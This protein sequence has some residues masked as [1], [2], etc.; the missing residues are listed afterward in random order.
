MQDHKH[1]HRRTRLSVAA[2]VAFGLGLT[3]VGVPAAFA[4]E[5][6]QTIAAVQ[7]TAETQGAGGASPLAGTTVTVEGIVTADH[8]GASGYRGIF[9]QALGSGGA[10]DATPGAS[11]GVFVYLNN[12]NPAV[13]IGDQ[14]TA[15]GVVTEYFGQTQL[16]AGAT[17][18]VVELVTPAAEVPAEQQV[19]A[20]AL[21]DTVVGADREAFEGM[22]VA[23]AGAY[24]VSSSHQL[25]NFGT[26]WLNA[27]ANAVKST[28]TTDAGADANAIAAA[29]RA[30]RILLDDGYNIQITNGSHPGTQPYFSTD[31]IVRGG[32]T[33]VWPA[34]PYVLG[35][36]FDDWRLQPTIPINDASPAEYK[37]TFDATNPRPGSAPAV[38]GDY[39]VGSF[40]VFN[41]FTTLT[42]E[43]SDARG[44]DN[45]ADFAIQQAKIVAAINALGADVVALQEI[46]NSIKLGEPAD[47]ALA[48]LVAAL[49]AAAGSAVWDYVRTPAALHN[50]AI[51]DFITNAII[52]KTDAVHTVGESFTQVDETV[53][54]IAR[55]P[56]AQT[57]EAVSTGKVFTV[58][59]NH[60]KSKSG[61]GA[62]P[63]DGQGHFN[64]ERVEQAGSLAALVDTIAADPEKSEDV[65]LVGDFNAYAQEDPIQVFTDAGYV[66][67]VPTHTDGQYT[68]TFDGELG[69]LDHVIAT[70]S[71][72]AYVTGA[73]VWSINS[74]EW[75]DRGYEFDSANASTVF[76]SSDH[77]PIKVGVSAELA[78]IEIE[79]LTVNDFHG[80]LEADRGI[81]GAAQIGGM[82]DFWEA[83]N[84]NTTFVGAGDFIGASTFTSFIQNDQPTID[85]LNA[86]GLDGSAL[87]NHEF[88]QGRADV[89]DRILN[90]ADWPY[91][92]ANLYDVPTG[93]P[94]YDE[95]FL[96]E[97][98]GVDVGFIGAVTEDLRELVSPAGIQSLEIRSIVDEVNRVADYLTDGDD[99]NGEADVLVLLVHEGAATSAIESS[100]DDSAFGQIVSDVSPEISAIVSGHT[101]L[102]YDHEVAVDGMDRP[103]LVISAGQYG[104]NY[105]HLDLSID[106]QTHEI[107]S[108]AGEVL[109]IGGFVPDAEVQAIVDEATA[110]ADVLGAVSVGEIT[111][112]FYRAVQSPFPGNETTPPNPFP[113]NRGGESTLGNF[114]ADVQLWAAAELGAHIA[115]MNPGGLRADLEVESSGEGDPDGNVTYRE[116][117]NVQPFANTLTT[118][119][120]TGAQLKQVLEEQWQPAG[121][122]RPFLKLGL[123]SGF[124]YV[125]DP[126]AAAG[127]HVTAMY[128]NGEAIDAAAEYK[129]VANS[130]LAAG[131]DNFFTLAEG[132]NVA[133]SGRV[134]LQA[135][136]DYF[137]E[138]PVATPSFEQNSVGVNP[139][140]PAEA[141]YSP[142]DEVTLDLS[143]LLFSRGGPTTGTVEVSVGET[144]LG[145]GQIDGTIVDT[146]DEQGRASVTVTI[147][148][149]TPSGVLLL[150]V[151]VPETGTTIDVPLEVTSDQEAIEVVD[152]PRIK[153]KAEVGK[154]L[155][156]DPGEW[157]VEDVEFSYQWL[158]DGQPIEGATDRK[159]AVTVDDI[160][161]ELS[162]M[163]TASKE[164]FANGT[165][166]TAAVAVDK[167]DSR[168]SASTNRFLIWGDQSLTVDVRVNVPKARDVEATGEVSIL[169]RGE[170]I[171]TATLDDRGRA[172][173]DLDDLESGFHWIT[174]EYAGTDLIDGSTSWP[175]L[176]V[177]F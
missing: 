100:T 162:A 71:A 16:G 122:Q 144:V 146:T 45:A 145:T 60:F 125:Y 93:E 160:G 62:E 14:V 3:T 96:Q 68:Y 89:D 130:F 143:S 135:M 23:P 8:R 124:E 5:P 24:K 165:A 25:H 7:G 12:A 114:V 108:F 175:H 78:P 107:L 91:V 85:V 87:G 1:T 59:A 127:S 150:T 149:G 17:P 31:T 141:G 92:A 134:D 132:T 155:R 140:P 81:P 106:P 21:A 34:N 128:L 38:G 118:M 116:A 28:E 176:V 11:D 153:G 159:Y 120:L 173:V 119:T 22:L 13:V 77:D 142:G 90:A 74:P 161:A 101:H 4:A 43:N 170:V 83:Q 126:D 86:I 70:P 79:I 29:N 136:V 109:P 131:G 40:N 111:D 174:V 52:F 26:L 75:S 99:T 148:E 69:S 137:E 104:A 163:V 2:V 48:D 37:P 105:G 121:A 123:S 166:E 19:S 67:L 168:V 49:N 9:V 156:V 58:V 18:A 169:V 103:R 61:S 139:T 15:T 157:S 57:F 10:A 97:F 84:S 95:Y 55:E 65:F 73:G 98:E 64:A 63:A 72:A 20:A 113:E 33:V 158:R 36:G 50:A 154:K 41:Y 32:D 51:T 129:I 82:V 102:A 164:G 56:I 172:S 115:L 110:V 6:D 80:R 133:D 46:E 147:P 66:D 151:T 167:L 152:E 27:G 54:D 138:N 42:S 53:W 88:D 44:A 35:Y 112:N 76:R 30:N 171:A 39:A 177:V 117:A 94:A 47:E